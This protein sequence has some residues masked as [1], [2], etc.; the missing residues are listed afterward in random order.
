ME[1]LVIVVAAVI[2]L[3]AGTVVVVVAMGC[4]RGAARCS[5]VWGCCS[6]G[7]D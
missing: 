4:S 6:H 1:G 2:V 3:C 7:C 5:A